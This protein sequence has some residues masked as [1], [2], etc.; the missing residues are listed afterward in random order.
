MSGQD[1]SLLSS[2]LVDN[3]GFTKTLIALDDEFSLME[4]LDL[5]TILEGITVHDQLVLV[6][7]KDLSAKHLLKSHFSEGVLTRFD[8]EFEPSFPNRFKKHS[9]PLDYGRAKRRVAKSTFK[10]AWYE[11][12][13]LYGAE[14]ASGLTAMAL[15]RQ[16]PFFEEARETSAHDRVCNLFTQYEELSDAL[17]KLRDSAYISSKNEYVSAPI[18]PIPLIVMKGCN[19]LKDVLEKSLEVRE[20]YKEL[21]D[22]LTELRATLDDFD[23][24]AKENLKAKEAWKKRWATLD[25]YKDKAA[26]IDLATASLDSI[27]ANNAIDDLDVDSVRIDKIIQHV[28]NFTKHGVRR[29]R[30]RLLHKTAESYLKEPHRELMGHIKRIFDYELTSKEA[31]YLEKWMKGYETRWK[32]AE[33]GGDAKT[34]SQV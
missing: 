19:S 29:W 18:P 24:P 34:D 9:I 30:V 33:Q 23:V 15:L 8:N 4:F 16:K 31:T 10:D 27:N 32:K 1:L 28:L 12:A 13:R 20:E 25:R 2:A 26:S 22:S 6:G 14:Q 5:C 7:E 3:Q 17:Q 21:R 11:S